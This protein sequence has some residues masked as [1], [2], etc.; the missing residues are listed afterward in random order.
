MTSRAMTAM[1]VIICIGSMFF[2]LAHP[3]PIV[4]NFS[5]ASLYKDFAHLWV[6]AMIG[7]AITCT[8][9]W[10]DGIGRAAL[11]AAVVLTVFELLVGLKIIG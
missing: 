6:G 9:W 2:I 10:R 11:P 8:R 1:T 7:L 3:L 5:W 4:L